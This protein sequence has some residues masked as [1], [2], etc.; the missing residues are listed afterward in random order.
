MLLV[1]IANR[2]CDKKRRN[3]MNDKDTTNDDARKLTLVVIGM[4]MFVFLLFGVIPLV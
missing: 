4:L 1:I 2:K 3:S